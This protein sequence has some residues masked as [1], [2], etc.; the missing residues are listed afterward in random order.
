MFQLN[1]FIKIKY[2]YKN[3]MHSHTKTKPINIQYGQ[4]LKKNKIKHI[5]ELIQL[6]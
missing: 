1:A 3:S 2:L 6:T 4:W 5:T